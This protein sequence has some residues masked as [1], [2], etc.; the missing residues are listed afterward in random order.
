MT[1]A[2]IIIYGNHGKLTVGKITGIVY[3]YNPIDNNSNNYDNI[4]KFNLNEYQK[5][6]EITLQGNERIDILN[7]GYWFIDNNGNRCYEVPV[8]DWKKETK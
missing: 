2:F 5:N 7:I 4:I 1:T 3:E 8:H 6:Y